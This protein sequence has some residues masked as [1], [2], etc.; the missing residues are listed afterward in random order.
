[1]VQSRRGFNV[2]ELVLICGLVGALAYSAA[3]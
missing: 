3:R 2:I 1:M